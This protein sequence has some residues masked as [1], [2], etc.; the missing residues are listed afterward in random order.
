MPYSLIDTS[1][2][3]YSIING[4][5]FVDFNAGQTFIDI[6]NTHFP[7]LQY[8]INPLCVRT[9]RAT[10]QENLFEMSFTSAPTSLFY[11]Y[12]FQTEG[13][14]RWNLITN[15]DDEARIQWR[16]HSQW[17]PDLN[18]QS[19]AIDFQNELSL[20][21]GDLTNRE[22]YIFSFYKRDLADTDIV[23]SAAYPSQAQDVEIA[24]TSNKSIQFRYSDIQGAFTNGISATVKS[25]NELIIHFKPQYLIWYMLNRDQLHTSTLQQFQALATAATTPT[26]ALTI[27][28]GALPLTVPRNKIIY[29]AP[30]TGKSYELREQA[31]SAGFNN[32]EIVRV[33]FHPSYSYQ[34]FIGSYKPTPVY[35]STPGDTSIFFGSD[36]VS[37]LAS[38]SD[39]EPL[40]DYS[41]VPG[42][43]LLQLVDALLNPAINYLLIIEEINR[44]AVASVFGDV[45]QLLDRSS[46]GESEYEIEFNADVSNYIKSRGITSPKIK[47]PSNFFIWATM[48]SADQGV[49]PMDAAFKRRWEFEFLP[50]NK[51]E[52]ETAS[53]EIDFPSG[54][55]NWNDFRRDLNNKLKSL[56]VAED[57]LIGPFFLNA[58]EL[59]NS[60][61]VKNKLLLYL[62]DD[63]VRHNPESLF[64]ADTFSDIAKAYDDSEEVFHDVSIKPAVTVPAS[65]TSSATN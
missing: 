55:I 21:T 8:T 45:F 46:T 51:K 9:G 59:A 60:S 7:T 44:A 56:G 12:C 64:L 19:K 25:N 49:Q 18:T 26:P 22:C 34:Q 32:S 20:A 10:R 52:S 4:E 27:P 47:L 38:P 58:V 11:V 42:P 2:N 24:G 54:K 28:A 43:L 36:K 1:I 35:K 50:L 39:K 5:P 37:Q 6:L 13:G 62:R 33:T 16:T 29:G 53:R 31:R 61:S 65:S 30:G 57:K 17:T 14:G 40:I 63:V 48:N 3:S 41:F 15:G 23:I